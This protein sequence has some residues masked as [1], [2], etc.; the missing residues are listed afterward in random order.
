MRPHLVDRVS[1]PAGKTVTRAKREALGN[2]MSPQNASEL[3]AAMED[4]VRAGTGTRAQIPG[5]RIAGKT[6]T[7]ETGIEGKNMTAFLCFAPVGAPRFAV[8][9]MLENQTGVGGT[10]AAPIAR[11]VLEALLRSGP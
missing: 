1:S 9:V 11:Q 5:V 2:V 4:A 3:A 8:A 7:A 6:G 10:T